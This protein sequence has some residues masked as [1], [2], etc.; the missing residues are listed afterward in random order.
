MEITWSGLAIATA[1]VLGDGTTG[2]PCG[3]W[4]TAGCSEG[5]EQPIG[6]WLSNLPADTEREPPARL[7]GLWKVEL[8][9]QQLKRELGLEH[10]EGRPW[11][12]CHHNMLDRPKNDLRLP[13]LLK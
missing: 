6:Y 4:L 11:L 8:D 3:E 10:Y 5:H 13:G 1:A 9:Y 12:G 7:A 2:E